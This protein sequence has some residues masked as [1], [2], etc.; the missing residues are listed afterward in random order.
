MTI[1]T[2][3][4]ELHPVYA[5]PPVTRDAEGRL[6]RVGVEVEFGRLSAAGAAEALKADLGGAIVEEDAHAFRLVGS[7]VGDLLVELDLRIT[8][9]A[10][11]EGTPQGRLSPTVARLVGNLASLVVP[12]ELVASPRPFA[13]L[14]DIDRAVGSLA[15]AGAAPVGPASFGLHFNVDPPKVDTDTALSFL[16]AFLILSEPLRASAGPAGRFDPRPAFPDAYAALVLDPAYRPD[17]A[18]FIADYIRHNP[19]RRRDLD[20]LPLLLVFDEARVRS[21]LPNEKIGR[22]PV[23]HYR[24]PAAAVGEP[25]WSIAPAWNR[26][27]AVERLATDPDQMARAL[28]HDPVRLAL[29]RGLSGS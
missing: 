21:A 5:M 23:L 10:R 13:D 1:H 26:W 24:L 12:R 19:T 29:A 8:H 16:R 28:A 15:R 22:R 6:R 3:E 17:T 18:G 7:A 14:A 9:P 20:L 27:V 11:H 4:I 2:S 25:G